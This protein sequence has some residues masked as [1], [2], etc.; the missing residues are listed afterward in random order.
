MQTET[1]LNG[2]LA[3]LVAMRDGA[4]ER[5]TERILADAGLTGD[6]I[7]ALTTRD[8]ARLEGPPATAFGQH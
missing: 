6:H 8:P 3:L 1:I 4:R 7:A 2:I 5:P